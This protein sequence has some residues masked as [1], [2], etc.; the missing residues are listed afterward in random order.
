[1]RGNSHPRFLGGSGL[2]TAPGYPTFNLRRNMEIE[3]KDYVA[4]IAIL[5]TLLLGLY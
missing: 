5:V 2:A 3:A 1:V 4:F